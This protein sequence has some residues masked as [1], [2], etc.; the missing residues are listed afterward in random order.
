MSKL[1][2]GDRVVFDTKAYVDSKANFQQ[3][4]W[5]QLVICG[6]DTVAKVKS[7]SFTRRDY[8]IN[9]FQIDDTPFEQAVLTNFPL[10]TAVAALHVFLGMSKSSSTPNPALAGEKVLIWGAGGAVGQYAVQYAAQVSPFPFILQL[11]DTG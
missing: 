8:Q 9:V 10:Q 5:Q 2:I 6:A 4:T 1:K 11:E 3:G 7:S